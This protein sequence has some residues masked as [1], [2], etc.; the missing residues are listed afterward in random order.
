MGNCMS[1]EEGSKKPNET[2]KATKTSTKPVF[3]GSKKPNETDK[4]TKTST[5][6]VFIQDGLDANAQVSQQP[7]SNNN[8]SYT[9]RVYDEPPPKYQQISWTVPLDV[10]KV[11]DLLKTSHKVTYGGHKGAWAALMER[12]RQIWLDSA[13]TLNPRTF[14]AILF[15]AGVLLLVGKALGSNMTFYF[16]T[17][18]NVET[19]QLSDLELDTLKALM[20]VINARTF[21]VACEIISQK[22]T[23]LAG[24][25]LKDFISDDANFLEKDTPDEKLVKLL[26]FTREKMKGFWHGWDV[27]DLDFEKLQSLYKR[28]RKESRKQ[29]KLLN[30]TSF[31]YQ[32][33]VDGYKRQLESGTIYPV[34]CTLILGTRLEPA[35]V[36]AIQECQLEGG[37]ASNEAAKE[38]HSRKKAPLW[39]RSTQPEPDSA[40]K[41]A[42]S[43]A[44][45]LGQVGH[46]FCIQ[47]IVFTDNLNHQAKEAYNKVDNYRQGKPDDINDVTFVSE[48]RLL[49]SF[50]SPLW[51][52]KTTTS[53]DPRVD[54]W[55]ELRNKRQYNEQRIADENGTIWLPGPALIRRFVLDIVDEDDSDDEEQNRAPRQDEIDFANG[56][57]FGTVPN[58]KH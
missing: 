5:K 2:D 55:G 43:V 10:E 21:R 19:D 16:T 4:A 45:E 25:G 47:G 36:D 24:Q 8:Q 39:R 46:Q 38:A 26:A 27:R 34:S 29:P 48:A 57:N 54:G 49:Y 33:A 12:H 56:V 30:N 17:F 13:Y 23:A 35:E 7:P 18:P 3:I 42:G 22:E 32:M 14:K 51:L 11:L 6:P 20:E 37:K 28:A 15:Y 31:I 44:E 50:L 58:A 41:N 9:L 52:F 1:S 40:A 53:H